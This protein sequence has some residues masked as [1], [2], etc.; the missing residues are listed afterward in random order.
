M[1]Q[2]INACLNKNGQN[3]PTANIAWG[4]FK[5]TGLGA[6]T[7]N[8]DAVRWE[9]IVP[10]TGGTYTGALTVSADLSDNRGNVR[11]I[12]LNT[13]NATYQFALADRGQTVIKTNTTAY[14]WTIPLEASVAFPN[15]TAITIVNDGTAGNI[16]VNPT[17]GVTLIDG[18]NTGAFTLVANN[19]R[20]LLKVGTNRW[21]V[22]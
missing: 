1:A 12:P 15:G 13:Q 5:I 2:G 19:A 9:Q 3:S 10:V 14:T 21:R 20:T 4:G 17:G 7:A 18:V 22:V 11:D 6:A 8:G 16:T